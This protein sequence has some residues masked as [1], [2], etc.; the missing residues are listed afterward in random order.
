MLDEQLRAPD[1]GRLYAAIE[2]RDEHRPSWADGEPVYLECIEKRWFHDVQ[3]DKPDS[4]WLDLFDEAPISVL[5]LKGYR[6]PPHES[7]SEPGTIAWFELG[8][9]QSG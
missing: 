9:V 8:F 2:V 7:E 6:L 3:R 4:D 1:R 5:E